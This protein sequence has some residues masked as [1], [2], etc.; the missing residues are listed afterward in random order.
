[1]KPGGGLSHKQLNQEAG[2]QKPGASGLLALDWQNGNRSTLTDSELS[3]LMLGL[4]LHSKPAEVFRAW[5]EATAFGARVIV[6]LYREYG[7][8]LNGLAYWL[9][10][11][12]PDGYADLCRC[13]GLPNGG[14]A[15]KR[16]VHWVRQ[17]RVRWWE[18]CMLILLCRLCNDE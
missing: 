4:S 15:D 11:K 2:E 16:A 6:E 12:E 17:W 5:V 10:K 14:I 1:M 9:L 3:G 7:Y 8:R 18:V 13:I